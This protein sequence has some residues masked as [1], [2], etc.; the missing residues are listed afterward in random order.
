MSTT[1]AIAVIL[2]GFDRLLASRRTEH[3]KY[4]ENFKSFIGYDLV[5][6]ECDVVVG[7]L[8]KAG[9]LLPMVF[10]QALPAIGR[11][12]AAPSLGT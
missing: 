2:S 4:G 5:C 11:L 3:A 12:E 10:A 6:G 8:E 9:S 7:C 1:R